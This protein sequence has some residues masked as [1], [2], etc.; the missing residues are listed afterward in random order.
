M[1]FDTRTRVTGKKDTGKV[2]ELIPKKAWVPIMIYIRDSKS[3]YL[4]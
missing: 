1:Q 4:R 2:G 3:T